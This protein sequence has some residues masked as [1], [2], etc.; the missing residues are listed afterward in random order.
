MYNGLYF[1][2]CGVVSEK[3]VEKAIKN[4]KQFINACS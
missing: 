2:D 4:G 3:K 1:I